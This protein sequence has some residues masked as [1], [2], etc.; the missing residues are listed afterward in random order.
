MFELIENALR[1][2]F[3]NQVVAGGLI[4]GIMGILI[5]SLRN[6]PAKLWGYAKRA[7]IVTAVID[8]RNELFNAYIAW[9]NEL[10][11]GRD[12]RLFTVIQDN[13]EGAEQIGRAHV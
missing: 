8:S 3:Q 9:L 6:L 1:E 2:Q 13:K 4:L 5:A 10:P 12:S 11:Y 7:F